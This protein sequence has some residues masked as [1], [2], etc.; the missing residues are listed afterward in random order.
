[1]LSAGVLFN[2]DEQVLRHSQGLDENDMMAKR[3]I[4]VQV[5]WSFVCL[6]GLGGNASGSAACAA[7]GCVGH[8]RGFFFSLQVRMMTSFFLSIMMYTPVALGKELHSGTSQG[9]TG[10]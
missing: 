8:D 2:R 4:L 9:A 3:S 5:L 1:M 10:S 7:S 6:G